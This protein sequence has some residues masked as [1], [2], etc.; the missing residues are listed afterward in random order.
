MVSIS[1]ITNYINQ[2]LMSIGLNCVYMNLHLNFTSKIGNS[3][4]ERRTR[5]DSTLGKSHSIQWG[6]LYQ[7]SSI[8]S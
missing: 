6:I 2:V 5:L 8:N 1:Q 7:E 4:F 3:N